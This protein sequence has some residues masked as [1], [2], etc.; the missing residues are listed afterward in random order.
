MKIWN[1]IFSLNRTFE[2]VCVLRT[3]GKGAGVGLSHVVFNLSKPIFYG[4]F[5]IFILYINIQ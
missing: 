5:K 4:C 2:Y 1:S 3:I